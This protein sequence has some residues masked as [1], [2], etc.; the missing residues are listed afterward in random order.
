MHTY[1]RYSRE[2]REEEKIKNKKTVLYEKRKTTVG[3]RHG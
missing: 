1:S 3:A 2:R